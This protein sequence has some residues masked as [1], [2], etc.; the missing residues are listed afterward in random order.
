M[1]KSISSAPAKNHSKKNADQK[2]TASQAKDKFDLAIANIAQL[3]D[4]DIF[5]FPIENSIFYD[6]PNET[7]DILKKI[8]ADFDSYIENYPVEKFSNCVPVGT[9]GFRW[10]TQID[11]IWNAYLLY[12]VLSVSESIEESRQPKEKETIHSYRV[13]LESEYPK[14][15]NKKYNWRSFI[16]KTIEIAESTDAKFIVKLDIGDFYTRIYHH[17]LEN[18]LIR[19]SKNT[20]HNKRIMKILFA[21]SNNTSYGLPIGGNAS[22]ILAELLLT[23]I[24]S[25]LTTKKI[26]FVRFVDDFVLFA[27]TKEDAFSY[28]NFAAEFLLKNE[29]LSIQKT[30]T[31]IISTAEYISQTKNF[32]SG[33]DDSGSEKRAEF[34]RLHI[35]YDPYSQNAE[36]EYLAL[37]ES[38]NRFDILSLLKDEIKKTKIH[39]AMGKQLLG[40]ISHLD[41]EKLSLAFKT[42]SSNMEA[43]YSIM[44]N[45]LQMAT[46]TIEKL[47]EEHRN[48]FINYICQLIESNSYLLQSE[49][50]AAYAARLLSKSDSE[51]STQALDNLYTR[52]ASTLIKTNCFYAMINKNQTHWLSDKKNSFRALSSPEKRAFIAASFFLGDEGRHWREKQKKQF[53]DLELLVSNWLGNKSSSI[54]K[55]WKLPL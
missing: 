17:R 46:K 55:G 12:L 39:Q 11:P 44:P 1:S 53:S 25:Q 8:D 51:E 30:K 35:N 31:Q 15:F 36:E 24:D 14:F 33:D 4:T 26:K 22:R 21:I 49:N 34:M 37:K 18:T 10:A 5:P 48:N 38:L 29:G 23:S 3:G 28:L 43:F 13:D 20:T 32:L 54:Q 19:A 16:E 9:S 27:K 50:N 42:I 45:L 2:D 52:R 41:G 40:A 6:M 7:K 47:P